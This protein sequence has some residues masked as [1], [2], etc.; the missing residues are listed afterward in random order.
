MLAAKT[1]R[2]ALEQTEF[3]FPR[4]LAECYHRTEER[5]RTNE[6]IDEQFD[7]VTDRQRLAV[8]D[9]AEGQRLLHR[10]KADHR[11]HR[12]H[13]FRHLE[14]F[15]V[16]GQECT[17]A[18]TPTATPPETSSSE[19][20]MKQTKAIRY[21]RVTWLMLIACFPDLPPFWP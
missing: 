8:N 5:N 18:A 20:W 11:V 15:D 17:D 16:L 3:V 6:G 12:R 13:Q 19:T 9:D 7:A 10:C 21:S 1:H 4:Q 2:L 14:H